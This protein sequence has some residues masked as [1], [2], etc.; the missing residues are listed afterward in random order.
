M[1]LKTEKSRR[2]AK[3]RPVC[4]GLKA[5]IRW[6]YHEIIWINHIAYMRGEYPK[7]G[8]DVP[9][10]RAIFLAYSSPGAVFLGISPPFERGANLQG[11][12]DKSPVTT[13]WANSSTFLKIISCPPKIWVCPS[14]APPNSE[15]WRRHRWWRSKRNIC[16]HETWRHNLRVRLIH[17]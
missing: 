4:M 11:G 2:V 12:G 3:W 13:A 7:G 16:V 8:S 17:A 1:S 14:N 9:G 10:G 5:L 6:K 15:G